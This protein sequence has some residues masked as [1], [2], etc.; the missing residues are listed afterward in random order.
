MPDQNHA[1][2]ARPDL[3]F[4]NL[5]VSIRSRATLGLAACGHRPAS[6]STPRALLGMTT[7]PQVEAS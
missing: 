5:P 3:V 2:F 1:S 6:P 7:L 4:R